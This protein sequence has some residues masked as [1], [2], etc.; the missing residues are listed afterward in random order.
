[1][2]HANTVYD[3]ETLFTEIASIVESMT[4]DWD[5][6]ASD[7]VTNDTRLI[8]DLMFESIDIV[9]FI[10]AIEERFH[11][12]DLPFEQLLM[13][14]GRYVEELTIGEVVTFLNEQLA[15]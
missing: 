6:S 7:G 11:R 14:D 3:R 12:Q 2:S 1:M 9:Q 5:T 4:A 8:A 15:S 10:V 13:V